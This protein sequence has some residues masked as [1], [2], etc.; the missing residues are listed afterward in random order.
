MSRVLAA[1]AVAA[2]ASVVGGL[3][4]P[5]PAVASCAVPARTSANPFVGTVT[6]V[7]N[8][9]RTATVRTDGGRTVIVQG[10][11]A[12]ASNSFTTVD[13]TFD[14]GVRYE[15]H[16]I[17]DATPYRDNACTAT[18]AIGAGAAAGPDGDT[19]GGGNLPFYLLEGIATGAVL[20]LAA[21]SLWLARE[22]RRQVVHVVTQHSGLLG[23][24]Q[25]AWD[26]VV[27]VI[28]PPSQLGQLAAWRGATSGRG[29]RG[30]AVDPPV[31]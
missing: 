8:Q 16:P 24:G 22:Q 1:L 30:V 25:Q 5:A 21:A 14:K 20:V 18:R 2:G 28:E 17:N 31:R 15:F 4:G 3:A 9:G 29:G 10:S 13:R 27:P 6:E 11:E 12:D 7:A 26:R 19:S 23:R